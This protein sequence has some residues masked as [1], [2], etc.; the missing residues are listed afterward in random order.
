MSIVFC[1]IQR[2]NHN[3]IKRFQALITTAKHNSNNI[4]IRNC[5]FKLELL[6]QNIKTIYF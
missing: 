3:V 4:F 2:Y 5:D 1:Q 6:S